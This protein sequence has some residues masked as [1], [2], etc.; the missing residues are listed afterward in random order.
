[1]TIIC[2]PLALD[3]QKAQSLQQSTDLDP[4]QRIDED[5]RVAQ[6]QNSYYII[7]HFHISKSIKYYF[8]CVFRTLITRVQLLYILH[9][10]EKNEPVMNDI[11]ILHGA[12]NIKNWQASEELKELWTYLRDTT[13]KKIKRLKESIIKFWWLVRVCV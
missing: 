13:D 1:M 10:N 8:R 2:T 5:Y 11:Q 12:Y 7:N 4:V 6:S 3:A 9:M